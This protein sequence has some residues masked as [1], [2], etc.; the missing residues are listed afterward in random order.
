MKQGEKKSAW[1]APWMRTGGTGK[2]KAEFDRDK[3]SLERV[4]HS[5]R[6]KEQIL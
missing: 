3:E 6:T 5:L 1:G 4:Q 2:G